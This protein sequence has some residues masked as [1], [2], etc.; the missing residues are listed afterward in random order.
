M[1]LFGLL[2]AMNLEV[3][4]VLNYRL[5]VTNNDLYKMLESSDKNLSVGLELSSDKKILK[6]PD[7][8]L[9]FEVQEAHLK[10]LDFFK[11]RGQKIFFL[12]N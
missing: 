1:K 2:E 6:F 4:G 5:P 12:E 7:S 8:P 9:Q 3:M 10:L 11:S